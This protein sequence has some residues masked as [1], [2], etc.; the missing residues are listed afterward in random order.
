MARDDWRG[1]GPMDRFHV[2]YCYTSRL[3]LGRLGW[4]GFRFHEEM[5]MARRRGAGPMDRFHAS[6]YSSC[7]RV[8]LISVG[9]AGRGFGFFT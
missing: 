2:K 8:V 6:I 9:S 1:A 5:R 7:G 4:S 3:D